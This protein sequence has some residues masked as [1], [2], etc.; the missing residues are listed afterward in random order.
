[1]SNKAG[2]TTPAMSPSSPVFPR[3]R[4]IK[5]RIPATSN[6]PTAVAVYLTVFKKRESSLMELPFSTALDGSREQRGRTNK[7]EWLHD[8]SKFIH[9]C[10]V[11]SRQVGVPI[12][13]F[14]PP[15]PLL[16]ESNP[17]DTSQH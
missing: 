4:T 10:K 7:E 8:A 1:M 17:H 14:P 11:R 6:T 16:L 13:R 3:A 9:A 12:G 2:A 15:G 5:V